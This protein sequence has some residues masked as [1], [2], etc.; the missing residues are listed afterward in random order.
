MD[1]GYSEKPTKVLVLGLTNNKVASRIY[2][3]NLSKALLPY[4]VEVVSGHD[5]FGYEDPVEKETI[6]AF[7]KTNDVDAV[8]VTKLLDKDTYSERVTDVT[9]M[10]RMNYARPSGIYHGGWY[11]DYHA[12]YRTYSSYDVSFDIYNVETSLYQVEGEKLVWTAFTST[13]TMDRDPENIKSLV[14]VLV[15]QLKKDGVI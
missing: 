3:S 14:K 15:K 9:S 4:G 7:V 5:V 13:E 8:I 12:G 2:E 6:S 10:G 1:D 11:G